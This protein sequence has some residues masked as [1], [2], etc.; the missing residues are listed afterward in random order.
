MCFLDFYP[1]G[2]PKRYPLAVKLLEN[3][4]YILLLVTGGPPKVKA[5]KSILFTKGIPEVGIKNTCLIQCNITFEGPSV[6]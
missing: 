6:Q 1:G 5:C 3:R 2:F 4:L